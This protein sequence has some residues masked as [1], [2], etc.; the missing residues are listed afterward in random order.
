VTLTHRKVLLP[1]LG[2][3]RP[4][5]CDRRRQI[6][7]TSVD[8][9]ERANCHDRLADGVEVDQRAGLPGTRPRGVGVAGPE[10]DHALLAD[11]DRE[12]RSHLKS[13]PHDVAER[14]T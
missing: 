4:V 2:E 8:E 11:M 13:R 5:A 10:I 14:V 1:A 7:R 9:P 3:L 12:R 6:E